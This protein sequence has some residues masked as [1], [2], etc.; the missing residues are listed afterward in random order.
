MRAA[1]S[2]LR[3]SRLTPS[4]PAALAQESRCGRRL[5][6]RSELLKLR[7]AEHSL[8]SVTARFACP[9]SGGGIGGGRERPG[10]VHWV[11]GR[12]PPHAELARALCVS[13]AVALDRRTL[14]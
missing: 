5:G 3:V 14:N 7:V 10:R 4:R 12:A 13:S 11:A 8:V 1:H 9:L 6:A 2:R